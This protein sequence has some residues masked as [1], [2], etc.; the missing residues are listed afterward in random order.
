VFVATDTLLFIIAGEILV[1][2][3]CVLLMQE[4]ETVLLSLQS[5]VC[6][7]VDIAFK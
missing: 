4:M 2:A 3:F 6:S 5:A 1:L 7:H